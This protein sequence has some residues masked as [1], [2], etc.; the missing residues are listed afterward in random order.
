MQPDEPSV[1]EEPADETEAPLL[2]DASAWVATDA[3]GNSID[4]DE[5][6]YPSPE[7]R[8]GKKVAIFYFLWHGCHGYDRPTNYNRVV[9][10]SASDVRSP[11][12]IQKLL[13]SNPSAPALGDY[14]VMH[15]WG[16]PYL[17]YYVSDDEWVIR[18]HAQMLSDAGVDAIFF[19]VTNGFHY[20]PVVRNLAE[21]YTSMRAQGNK[22][23]QFAFLLNSSV[24]NM[25]TELWEA[26]YSAGQFQDLWFCWDGKPLMLANPD[27]V[28]EGIRGH[29]TLRR[30]WFLFNK[31]SSDGW[32]GSGEDKWPW[33]A[34]YPQ[35]AG[36]HN[37]KNECV[38]VMPATHPTSGIGR[39]YDVSTGTEP[40]VPTPGK[41]I[42]FKKQFERA[43]DLDPQLIFFTGWNEWTA[44][45]QRESSCPPPYF[46]DQYNHEFS[47][48]IEPLNGDFGDNY[49]YMMA[50]FIRKFKGA[51]PLPAFGQRKSIS[52]DGDFS[53]WDG[54][55][56]RWAD[57]MGDICHRDWFGWG[58]LG[59]LT[60]D[61]GR[62]D[63]I[64]TKVVNDGAC[65][66]FYVKTASDLSPCTDERW[67]QLFL[68]VN[69]AA[70]NWEGYDFVV[71]RTVPAPGRSLLEKS[72]GGWAW[73]E[74]A[75]V[76]FAVTGNEMEIAV[77]F[78]Y[79]GIKDA[80]NFTIDFKWVD[81]AAAGGDIQTCMRDGDSAPNGRFRYRYKFLKQSKV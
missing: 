42:Y 22:T 9:A 16:E 49:Y 34:W 1:V 11:Y 33:G 26:L 12:D 35:Q 56:A 17:G 53:D 60:N 74:A 25:S 79:L 81:N 23:P 36:R 29:F 51:G 62:N 58:R 57:D 65:L 24:A 70:K 8:Q 5:G 43:M 15:H 28:P 68:R 13:D 30:S 76:K 78:Y 39:S 6:L 37:G 2:P 77:P 31:A 19:D 41:G 32:F 46:V 64:L 55:S 69:G 61:T 50:D 21:I 59:Q 72:D 45:R 3:Q 27:E 80:G 14:G 47:R 4:P 7:E 40:P 75:E 71:N 44:Q 10:P 66:Y 48:D 73:K 63:I 18:K 20:L 38:S 52:I 54:V 67:M